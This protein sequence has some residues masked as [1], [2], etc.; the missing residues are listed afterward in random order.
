V[1]RGLYRKH[2]KPFWAIG[3]FE[4]SLVQS[5][6]IYTPTTHKEKKSTVGVVVVGIRRAPPRTSSDWW[7]L[8]RWSRMRYMLL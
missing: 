5:S 8:A 4:I 7:T 6:L 1:I 3:A 2:E